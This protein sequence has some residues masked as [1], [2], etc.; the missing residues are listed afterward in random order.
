M[1]LIV[2]TSIELDGDDRATG[3][4][5]REVDPWRPDDHRV[6]ATRFVC[7]LDRDT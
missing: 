5:V 2:V 1:A 4:V 3:G 6:I 7:T